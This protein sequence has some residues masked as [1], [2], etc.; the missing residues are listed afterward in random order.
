M[1]EAGR[2]RTLR[3]VQTAE[4]SGILSCL[5]DRRWGL[6]WPIPFVAHE[7]RTDWD[8]GGWRAETP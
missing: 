6:R 1:G 4:P 8:I 5:G 3:R 2:V 7:P